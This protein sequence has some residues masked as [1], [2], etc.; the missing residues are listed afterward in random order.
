[1]LY[2]LPEDRNGCNWLRGGSRCPLSAGEDAQYEVSMPI[3]DEYPEVQVDI[4]VR[5]F[6]SIGALQFCTVVEG[7]VVP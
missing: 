3:T 5:L 2:E 4:E 6:N 7:R 1:M